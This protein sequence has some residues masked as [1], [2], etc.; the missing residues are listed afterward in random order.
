MYYLLYHSLK[1]VFLQYRLIFK[2][3]KWG[4][5]V[6]TEEQWQEK[7]IFCGEISVPLDRDWKVSRHAWSRVERLRN[8]FSVVWVGTLLHISG[9]D[10]LQWATS[11]SVSFSHGVGRGG[12]GDG[13]TVTITSVLK[14]IN[15]DCKFQID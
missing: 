4:L 14:M 3:P 11:D 10:W 1:I 2:T 12:V 6:G 8:M 5:L 15:T 9:L 13:V 7:I